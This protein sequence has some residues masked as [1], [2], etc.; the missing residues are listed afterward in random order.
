MMCITSPGR[1]MTESPRLH[2]RR[3]QPALDSA[4]ADNQR[5]GL[6]PA[7]ARVAL[8]ASSGHTVGETAKLL[9][10]FPNTI[11]THLRRVFAKTATARQA[12][13]ARADC[14]RRQCAFGLA[15]QG[16]A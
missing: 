1:V 13:L 11:E 16:H 15:D 5:Y 12:E 8:A 7:E 4:R 2:H 6:T 10:L 3:H 14:G 9:N